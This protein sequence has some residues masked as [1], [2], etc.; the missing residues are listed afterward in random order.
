[1][2]TKSEMNRRKFISNSALGSIG[3]LSATGMIASCGRSNTENDKLDINKRLRTGIVLRPYQLLCTICSIGEGNIDFN[4]EKIKAIR[5]NPDIPV[6]LVCNAGDVFTFQDPGNADDAHGSKEFNRKRDLEILQRTD[7]TPG[8]TLPARIILHRIWDRIEHVSGICDCG[9]MTSETCKGCPKAQAGFYEKGREISLLYAVPTCGSQLDFSE[10][11]LPKAKNALIVPRTKEERAEAKR[12]SLEE[13]YHADAISIRPHI[14][15]CSIC[16]YGD[17]TRPPFQGDNLP[18]TLQFILKNPTAKIRFAEAADWMMCAPCTSYTKCHACV[19]IEGHGGLANQ[20][21][22][23]R[24]LQIL[25]FGYGD[26]I[27]AH[28]LFCL[29]FER[30]P[31]TAS[32]CGTISKGVSEPSVWDDA[33]GHHSENQPAYIKGREELIREFGFKI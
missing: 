10:A 26:V 19:N 28:E 29:I 25:G 5:E 18:E 15:L 32:V 12:K 11:D 13:V 14:V 6:T 9:E 16:Q 33:C 21:R 8:V 22:D 2:K 24:V 7:L 20:L 31:S 4:D 23:V 17:G 1:M 27:N 30:I 3:A